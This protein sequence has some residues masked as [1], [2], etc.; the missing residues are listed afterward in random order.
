MPLEEAEGVVWAGGPDELPELPASV[1]WVQLP[2]AGVEPWMERVR[3][4]PDVE[5]T[6]AGGA[7]AT[8]VAELALGM[9]LAGVRGMAHY[10]RTKTLGSGRRRHARGL[11]GGDRRRRRDRPAR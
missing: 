7:Y 4:T 11:D 5:F 3:A 2:A 6:S 8:Q 9:L 1:R 10:A